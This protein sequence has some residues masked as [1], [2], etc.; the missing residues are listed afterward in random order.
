MAIS[1][2]TEDY[3]VLMKYRRLGHTGVYV[4]ELCLGAMTFGTEWELIGALRQKEAD[5]LVNRSIDAGINFFDTADVYST[6]DSEEILGRS[7]RDKRHDV[8]VATKVRGRMGKGPNEVGLS[9]L[10]I[11]R[12]CDASLKRLGTDYIDLYQIHRADPETHIEETLRALT[13]LVKAGKVR[14]I[15]CSNLEAWELMKALGISQQQ[16][17][18]SFICTQSYYALAGRDI[19]RDTIPLIDDQGLGLLVWSPLAGG[20]LSG[21]FTRDGSNDAD[22]RRTSFDFPPIDKSHVFDIIDAMRPIAQAHN[23]SVAQVAL[24]WLLAKRAVTSI[25]IGAKR[26]DQ[27]A[28]NLGAIDLELTKEEM[29]QLDE[30]SATPV[31]Y[32]AWM[33]SLGDDR[34]PGTARDLAAML[35]KSDSN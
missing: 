34:L 6:G 35:K 10:H 18:E 5:A 15:G 29:A 31:P 4:S 12:A 27:L 26:M 8:V 1:T 33:L 11:I 30:V 7:L 13:D 23:A 20:L 32:P 9:R 21:K 24:A 16:T 14:Y 2:Q 22:A 25:I 3:N 17:L 28:D 19:E